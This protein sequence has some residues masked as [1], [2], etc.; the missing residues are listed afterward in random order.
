[1]RANALEQDIRFFKVVDGTRKSF[2]VWHGYVSANAWHEMRARVRRHRFTIYWDGKQVLES[3]DKTLPRA[4][5][6]GLWTK[7]D[8]VAYFDDFE[9]EAQ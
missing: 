1:M 2:A 5:K 3:H 8:S 6:A 4:G 9:I 7:A